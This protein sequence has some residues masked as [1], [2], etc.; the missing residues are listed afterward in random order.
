MQEETYELN[1][2]LNSISKYKN[3]EAK[4][5]LIYDQAPLNGIP[6]KW[7]IAFFISLPFIEYAGIFNPWMFNLLG[8]AQAIIFF[9][10]FLSMVM[11][12][13]IALTFINN[14]KVVRQI[15]PS[16][17]SYF[18]NVDLKMVLSS[19]AT[20][21]KDFFKHYTIAL[22]NGLENEALYQSLQNS[23]IQMETENSDLVEAINRK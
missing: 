1:I 23:F 2:I 3:Q 13:V 14:N 7:I 4:R 11:I 9:V 18:P 20:P 12:L 6:A 15:T 22:R 10:V 21:Y 17:K 8:I 19:G 5:R 16:W